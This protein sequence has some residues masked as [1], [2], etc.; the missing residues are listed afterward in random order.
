MN[1]PDEITQLS[2]VFLGQITGT[3]VGTDIFIGYGWRADSALS[4]AM[5]FFQLV[6]LLLRGPHCPGNRW[7]GYE[8]GLEFWQKLP[9]QQP[10]SIASDDPEHAGGATL[11]EVSSEKGDV[12]GKDAEELR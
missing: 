5:Y 2:Q 12:E 1:Q 3:S 11:A 8:G 6:V 9:C 10:E 7:F 4:M